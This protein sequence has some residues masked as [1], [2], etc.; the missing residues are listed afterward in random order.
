MRNLIATVYFLMS[1]FGWNIGGST[2]V[3][4]S[5]IDGI[6]QLHSRIRT[7]FAV[8]RFECL[9]STSGECHYTLFPR[10]CASV[11]DNCHPLPADR[12]TMA[13]GTAREVVGLPEFTACVAPDD[14]MLA[15]DCKPRKGGK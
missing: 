7:G 15:A 9:A 6:E 4:R 12:I 5:A 2:I 3:H 1:L 10:P 14:T 13:A 11:A 8:T